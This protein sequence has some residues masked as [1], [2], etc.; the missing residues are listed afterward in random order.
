MDGRRRSAYHGIIMGLALYLI[1]AP[2][3]GKTSVFDALTRTPGS[4]PASTRGGHRF[5]A[6]KVPDARLEALREL[7]HPKKFTPAEVTFC[8]LDPAAGDGTDFAELAPTLGL[9]DAFVLVVQAFGEVDGAGKPLDPAAQFE[10]LMLELTI[11][12]FA[13]LEKRLERAEQDHRHGGKISEA[14]LALLRRCKEH[15]GGDQPLRTMELRPDE[16]KI[17]RTY[18]FL[19]QK[20]ILAV[21]DVAE[22]R[23]DGVGLEPLAAQARER[24]VELLT[25]CAP[26]ESEI[27]QLD[28]AEQAEFLKDYQ[29][30]EPARI[31]LLHAAYR[32]LKLIS[33]F[34]VGEDEVRAWTLNEGGSAQEAAG[35]IHTDIERGFIRAETVGAE[36]LLKAGSLAKCREQG[37]LRLEGKTYPVR[38]GE[39]LHFRFS[40]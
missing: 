11:A 40:V 23:R 35:K 4:A 13:R 2:R 25:F 17:L 20:P 12:D 6:V 7:F 33:F 10:S 27:A 38:D 24:G 36:D 31:R 37:L 18:Q 8:D 21:A 1:G 15:L 28:P 26:L 3:C 14:E 16:E 30:A 29:I 39:V 22:E 9:A 34:T 19:S 5:G 32:T